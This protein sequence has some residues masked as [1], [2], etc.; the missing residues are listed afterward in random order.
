MAATLLLQR[1]QPFPGTAVGAHNLSWCLPS[2]SAYALISASLDFPEIRPCLTNTSSC[3]QGPGWPLSHHPTT[4][5]LHPLPRLNRTFTV[6]FPCSDGKPR[7][8]GVGIIATSD[9]HLLWHR[10][11]PQYKPGWLRSGRREWFH[12]R[13]ACSSLFP[14]CHPLGSRY[15]TPRHAPSVNECPEQDTEGCRLQTRHLVLVHFLFLGR[16]AGQGQGMYKNRVGHHLHRF[17]LADSLAILLS[18]LELK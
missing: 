9:R 13:C 18:I 15:D 4:P 5:P 8:P 6:A 2:P 10:S 16:N 7:I 1:L 17:G 3:S 14:P 12:R 11:I